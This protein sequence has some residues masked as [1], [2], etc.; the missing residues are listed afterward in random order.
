MMRWDV[1]GF[2]GSGKPASPIRWH[3]VGANPL[4]DVQRAQVTT[5]LQAF[6]AQCRL[7][8]ASTQWAN[9]ELPDGSRYRLY[10]SQGAAEVAIEPRSVDTSK[11]LNYV[12]W[13][14][15]YD[16]SYVTPIFD[17]EIIRDS[18]D[19][20]GYIIEVGVFTN[21]SQGGV[22]FGYFQTS[23]RRDFYIGGLSFS[24][25]VTFEPTY[26]DD[27]AQGLHTFTGMFPGVTMATLAPG[28]GFGSDQSYSYYHQITG[29]TVTD[30][31]VAFRTRTQAEGGGW[32]G[33][34]YSTNIPRNP[35]N[36]GYFQGGASGEHWVGMCSG[37]VNTATHPPTHSISVDVAGTVAL[38]EAIIDEIDGSKPHPRL[39]AKRMAGRTAIS[40][41]VSGWC[42][43]GLGDFH[44]NARIL[45]FPYKTKFK[46]KYEGFTN[47]L[48]SGA[49]TDQTVSELTHNEMYKRKTSRAVEHAAHRMPNTPWVGS[50]RGKEFSAL[51]GFRSGVVSAALSRYRVID[52]FFHAAEAEQY[53]IDSLTNAL[54]AWM[55]AARRAGVELAPQDAGEPLAFDSQIEVGTTLVLVHLEYEVFDPYTAQWL[56]MAVPGMA[57][58]DAVWIADLGRYTYIPPAGIATIRAVRAAHATKHRR[59]AQGWG[60]AVV[61]PHAEWRS[62]YVSEDLEVPSAVAIAI[63]LTEQAYPASSDDDG[64]LWKGGPDDA[65]V[66]RA[67]P[68]ENLS[69]I[70]AHALKVA[71]VDKRL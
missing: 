22:D 13:P 41:G 17:R 62:A 35:A 19:D 26:F 48:L 23:L 59:T 42:R 63:N 4:L 57:Q 36:M 5:K 16:P 38:C 2:V 60:P 6:L 46:P 32:I 37:T 50:E 10:W 56:W 64:V 40:D 61:V 53:V 69:H 70:C 31:S 8:L 14:V 54:P 66:L 58:F 12:A 18:M 24:H 39:Q 71:R 65:S 15:I 21:F 29:I 44:R 20:L 27:G 11:V 49:V 33:G 3:V 52:N 1:T 67:Q 7:S 30:D 43:G 9:G 68:A 51:S 25:E 34:V 28:V 47:A 45:N 55:E